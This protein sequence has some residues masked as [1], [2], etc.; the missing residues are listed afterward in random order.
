MFLTQPKTP[1]FSAAWTVAIRKLKITPLD[2]SFDLKPQRFFIR[3]I[4][5]LP[6]TQSG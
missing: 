6:F 5:N 3:H 4:A 2:A 1:V